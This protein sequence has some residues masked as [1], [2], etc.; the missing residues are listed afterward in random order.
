[1]RMLSIVHEP[2]AGPGVFAEVLDERGADT[3]TWRPAEDPDPPALDGLSAILAFGGAMHVDQDER[4][5]WLETERT[6]LSKALAAG[7]PL[8]AVC[9]GSQLLAQAAGAAVDRSAQPEI[10][11]HEVSL[12]A[13]G[14]T[15]PLLAALDEHL[16]A[17]HWHAYEFALPPG[18]VALAR[19]DVC[20]Q[21]FRAG[22]AAW[23]I[24]FHAEVS[25]ADALAWIDDAGDDPDAA[26]AGID[27]D[28][29][30]EQTEAAIEAWNE[31]GRALCGR[32]L[33]AVATPA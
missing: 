4:H 22:E 2:T 13:E 31:T 12:T 25:R 23:G 28:T 18:A 8:L 14:A 32:F 1:M 27:A 30:R 33:D 21:A 11:W 29:L 6:L 5:P 10:G 24:Q 16:Q 26:A 17:F 19:S 9:L 15:D 20:L 3:L 7:I